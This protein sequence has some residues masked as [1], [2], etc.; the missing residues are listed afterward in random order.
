MSQIFSHGYAV[1]I[2][3][4]AD[5]P[6]T[7]EDANAVSEF[8]ADPARCAYPIEQ[9]RLL[10]GENAQ[11][12]N[13]VSALNWLAQ[14]AAQD[15]TAI[16]YFSGHGTEGPDFHLVPYGFDWKDLIGT[17]IS[18]AEFTALLRKIQSQKLLVLLDCCHAGGQADAKSFVKSPMPS[19]A[20]EELAHGS[21]R[22]VI[23]SSRKDEVSWTGNPYSQFTMAVLEALCGL[24]AFEQDGFVRVLDL[25]LHVGRFVPARTGDKQHPI[26][27]VSNL[28]DNFA[29][30]WFAGGDKIPKE[31]PWQVNLPSMRVGVQSAEVTS[32]RRRLANLRENLLLIDERMSEFVEFISIPL[33]LIKNKRQI[34]IEIDALL[35]R[36][37]EG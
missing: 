17:A 30:A 22:V 15:D 35:N 34:E 7:I 1:V 29:I 13:I 16:I 27:K 37:Q 4:G 5:L 24:G 11:R 9:V 3:V 36:L 33:Q 2:G 10:T 8:L 28:Q 20:L 14:S 32:F 21:G 19:T 6:V 26:I 18:G 31:L 12:E 25:T 23:A